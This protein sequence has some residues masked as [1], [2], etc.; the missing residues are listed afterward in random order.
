MFPL[1]DDVPTSITPYIT[2]GLIGANIGIFLYQLTLNQQQLQEF[3][4]SAA[5]VPCQLSGNIVGRC[6][7]PT[8]QQLPEWMT[9][10]SSQFLHGGFL[11]IAGNMLFLWIFGNNVEDRLGHVKFLI[12]YLTCG[13]LAAL[14]QWF[15]SPNSTI[16]SLG[17]SG[18]IAG[19]MGA[20]ILRYPQARVLTLVFLGFFV[21]TLQIPAIFFLGLWFVQQALYGIA[22]LQVPSNIGMESG[23]VA[24]WAHAG[25]FVFGA[26]LAPMF[27]LLKRD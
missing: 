15:F 20:Y 4:Y 12:F 23:G 27:G 19:V 24:Y 3:F 1:R 26:I 13:V 8:P 5:V 2:Y 7:I 17:A 9:L 14:S 25:G 6:P 18:A 11:H 16:P 10:I 22:S 21:T